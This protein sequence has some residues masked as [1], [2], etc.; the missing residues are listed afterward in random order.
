MIRAEQ[1]HGQPG[2]AGE[3]HMTVVVE[4]WP[5]A[6]DQTGLWL[7][8]P[9]GPWPSPPVLAD[10]EPHV[11]AEIELIQHSVNLADVSAIHSTSWRAE[12]TSAV[13]TYLAVV[14]VHGLVLEDWPSARPISLDLA[15][16]VGRPPTHGP[17]DPPAPRHIDVLIHGL[18]H[19]RFLLGTDAT[20][21]E[22]LGPEWRRHLADLEPAIACMYSEVHEPV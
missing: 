10:S 2:A 17:L 1:E 4:V 5:V 16:H 19:L 9:D 7:L 14:D 13:L 21:A 18:R 11:A 22:A 12:H 6:A 15:Q 8:S 3:Q 20:V